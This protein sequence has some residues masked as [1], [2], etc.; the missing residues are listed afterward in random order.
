MKL[1][2]WFA[3]ATCLAAEEN[4]VKWKIEGPTSVRAGEAIRVAVTGRIEDGYHIYSITQ[5]PGGPIATTIT[6]ANTQ[7]WKISGDIIGPPPLRMHDESFDIDVESYEGTARFRIPVMPAAETTEKLRIAVRYQACNNR[8]CLPPKT[9][10]LELPVE[11]TR[12]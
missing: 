4:P 5:P 7:A 2:I 9:V 1:P 8:L 3:L 11:V 6:V 10:K 12:K